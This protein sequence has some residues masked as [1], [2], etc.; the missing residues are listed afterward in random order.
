M[1]P[2]PI[3]SRLDAKISER[4]HRDRNRRFKRRLNEMLLWA[5][6]VILALGGVLIAAFKYSYSMNATALVSDYYSE[7]LFAFIIGIFPVV[8]NLVFGGLPFETIRLMR[9]RREAV[10]AVREAKQNSEAAEQQSGGAETPSHGAADSDFE[11][12]IAFAVA[13]TEP[14]DVPAR[15]PLE[16][17]HKQSALSRKTAGKLF[18]RAG[19]YLFIGVM[20]A[21]TGL[22]FFYAAS[23]TA[24]AKPSADV[25]HALLDLAPRFGILFFIEFL[26]FFFLKQYRA[27]IDEFRYYEAITRSREEMVFS[28]LALAEAN[29]PPMI[30]EAIR[31][32]MF[33]SKVASLA[34]GHTTELLETRKV[35]GSDL[36]GLA[37]ILEGV[38]A[39]K[40]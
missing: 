6:F 22:A 3:S 13:E 38:A 31:A 19:V 16:Q 35:E 37:K 33:S 32:G 2:G 28:Y 1:S 36:A 15:T 25:S 7:I 30:A 10:R 24:I 40:K 4:E 23:S 20:I 14:E 27:A 12:V 8:F 9:E 17:L 26:A 11:N 18:G 29:D 5:A 39:L 34:P 21:A